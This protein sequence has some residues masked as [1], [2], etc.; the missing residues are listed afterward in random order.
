ME[1]KYGMVA[2]AFVLGL[3]VWGIDV[4]LMA[5][6]VTNHSIYAGLIALVGFLA[7]G[8][9][10]SKFL[11]RQQRI[12][13]EL[14]RVNRALKTLSECNQAMIRAT[15]ESELLYD[16]CRIIV[17]VG[18]YHLAWVG[19]AEK[20]ESRTVKPAAQMGY[21]EAYLDSVNIT[22][23][24]TERGRGPTGTAIRTGQPCAVRNILTDPHF[25]PW[26]DEAK[27]RGYASVIGLPLNVNGN[28]FGALTIYAQ[29][30]DAFDDDE[31]KLLTDL[32]DDLTYGI[33]AL[34]TQI[35]RQQV[36]E[37]LRKT[38]AKKQAILNAIPDM[39][40]QIGTDGIYRGVK[41][42]NHP[43]SSIPA[44]EF[45]GKSVTEVLP[46]EVAK[47]TMDRVSR[48][49]QT[50]KTQVFEYQLPVNRAHRDFEARL[51]VCSEDEVTTIVRDITERKTRE[52]VVEEE[53]ARIARDLHDGL[54]QNLYFVG[55]KLD[56][57]CKKIVSTCNPEE[58]SSEL[59]ALKKTVQANIDDVR[60][61]IFSLRPV[62]LDKL[63]FVP[64]VRKYTQE[65]GEQTRLN[66][67][68]EIT[69]DERTLPPTLEPIFFR[70]VQEGLNNIAK[71][72]R[73]NHAW[74]TLDIAPNQVSHLTIRDDGIG[75]NV[76]ALSSDKN[77]K[78]GLRQMRER[79]TLLGGQF[80]IVSTPMQGTVLSAEIPL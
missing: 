57:L 1:T 6:N 5:F 62:E 47:Q 60:R 59:C 50:G 17:D 41:S 3:I 15:E 61:T 35:E 51:V 78:M 30:T 75:F 79:V 26:R 12:E 48:A 40:V 29:E 43:E 32:A 70:L 16:I 67:N 33:L 23:A 10:A 64:A 77:G 8:L 45:V 9:L 36:E 66:V 44:D 68:L 2:L 56:Y 53:R 34:R 14:C 7:L 46:D 80:E 55:L 4:I 19:F 39:I 22:W 69:G 37:I 11:A 13:K 21:E 28:P 18:G 73:A 42:A 72:A 54:A 27:K 49:V 52:A 65:F 58:M 71:H 25:S 38:E 20:N 74:I 24:N 63:G 76:D 31:V